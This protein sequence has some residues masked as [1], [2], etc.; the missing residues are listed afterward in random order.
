M[1]TTPDNLLF[2]HLIRW[3]KLS[4]LYKGTDLFLPTDEG[5]LREEKVFLI[6]GQTSTLLLLNCKGTFSPLHCPPC[7]YFSDTSFH[8]M[9]FNRAVCSESMWA[10]G[11]GL[12]FVIS[13]FLPPFQLSRL[14]EH[15]LCPSPVRMPMDFDLA[16]LSS[17]VP[18]TASAQVSLAKT[19]NLT[20]AL[21]TFFYS[22]PV[23]S[24]QMKISGEKHSAMRRTFF[25]YVGWCIA[26]VLAPH[27]INN[28]HWC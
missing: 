20:G 25:V 22:R 7:S 5:E 21:E 10:K 19:T 18:L 4:Q 27:V 24:G 23:S 15:P 11:P 9:I 2:L 28:V 17:I 8:E 16:F 14:P 13:V 1:L 12:V 26:W 6:H 3:L